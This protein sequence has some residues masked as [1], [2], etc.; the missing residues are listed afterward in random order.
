MHRSNDVYVDATYSIHGDCCLFVCKMMLSLSFLVYLLFQMIIFLIL[1]R[2][3]SPSSTDN[4]S[5]DDDNT[6]KEE[7]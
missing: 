4:I 5:S 7:K 3:T 1:Q 6:S 2:D